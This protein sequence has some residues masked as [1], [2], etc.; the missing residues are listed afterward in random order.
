MHPTLEQLLAFRDGE[1][2]EGV[3]DHLASCAQCAAELERLHGVV[4]GLRALPLESPPKDL[5]PALRA[6]MR[7]ESKTHRIAIGALAA[8]VL[9]VVSVS[10]VVWFSH[11][12][13][14]GPKPAPGAQQQAV[15]PSDI[16]PLITESQKLEGALRQ[17][18]TG[19]PVMSGKTAGAIANIE[20]SIA[21]L[22]FKISLL[23][24]TSD[25]HD[26]LKKL[27]QQRVRLLQALVQVRTSRGEYTQL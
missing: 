15:Q 4:E 16:Q 9:L 6:R 26:Q 11:S 5:W 19:T 14:V 18:S 7:G 22:D 21:I 23:K 8:A 24:D 17:A 25:Q 10:T 1:E 27:W 12:H 13:A 3:R 20:D 2:P